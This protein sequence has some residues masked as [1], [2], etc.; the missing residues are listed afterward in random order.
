VESAL[1]MIM[2][3]YSLLA[4]RTLSNGARVKVEHYVKQLLESGENAPPALDGLRIGIS[5]RTRRKERSGQSRFHR[6][7]VEK[8]TALL[9]GDL[10]CLV[11]SRT[12]QRKRF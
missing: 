1:Q 9:L 5:P 3:T 7:L 4:S 2:Q 11:R 10:S 6:M 8:A 12:I